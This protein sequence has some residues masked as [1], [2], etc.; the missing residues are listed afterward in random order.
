MW[1]YIHTA[2]II[3]ALALPCFGQDSGVFSN[4]FATEEMAKWCH[5][6][7]VE[8]CQ[9]AGLAVTE[10]TFW[11]YLLGKNHAKLEN[12]KVD[13]KAC[14]PYYVKPVTNVLA[15]LESEGITGLTFSNDTQF[16]TYCGL[17]TNALD[18]TPYF[19]SQYPNVT[20]GW[21]NVRVMLTNMVNTHPALTWIADETNSW[22]ARG[23]GSNFAHSL[24]ICTSSWSWSVY[25]LFSPGYYTGVPRPYR[26]FWNGHED[27]D[28]ISG[29]YADSVFSEL[30]YTSISNLQHSS[31]FYLISTKDIGFDYESNEVFNAQSCSSGMIS[32][33]WANYTNFPESAVTA[34]S[35]GVGVL[36]DASNNPGFPNDNGNV[37]G[38]FGWTILNEFVVV[39]WSGT[40]GFKYK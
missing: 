38:T 4:Y 9:A 10:P 34:R 30:K 18:E 15:V 24:S 22:N 17:A 1:K 40:N 6:G 11:D 23:S 25:D 13:I 20:G 29:V 12:V 14:I 19:K 32:T 27:P 3:F 31:E 16:L 36:G 21:Q 5:S 37:R 39:K 8:R 26:F 7:R 28:V 33:N 35:I 2:L